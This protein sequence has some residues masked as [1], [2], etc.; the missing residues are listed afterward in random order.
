MQWCFIN[1]PLHCS[2]FTPFFKHSGEEE[3]SR[4]KAASHVTAVSAGRELVQYAGKDECMQ[5]D[6]DCEK[7]IVLSNLCFLYVLIKCLE[8]LPI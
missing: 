5:I 6:P 2:I 8:W 1:L 4:G 7:F 3:N